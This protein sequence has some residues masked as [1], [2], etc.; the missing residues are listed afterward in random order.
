[1][2]KIRIERIND[3]NFYAIT[4]LRVSK[5]QKHFVADNTY[6]LVHAYL[7]LINGQQAF[8]FGIFLG[9]K[10]IGF[11]MIGYDA[12]SEKVKSNPVCNW[13][14]CDSYMIWRLMI[15]KRY[16]GN[17]YAKEAMKLALDFVRSFPCGEAEYCW[18]SYDN[19]NET[20][21]SLYRS[22]GF[23]E[24]PAAYYEGGEMP[25]ILKLK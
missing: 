11:L 13:F 14:M 25:A 15:D 8:P 19:E 4:K 17:G 24:V 5:E 9:D 6:S 21:R 23:E 18:L 3:D 12:M 7:A 1:M 20:A 10:P 16:Q 22:F 2:D